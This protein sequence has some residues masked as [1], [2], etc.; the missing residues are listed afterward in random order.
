MQQAGNQTVLVAV[1]SIDG[2]PAG[3]NTLSHCVGAFD[4]VI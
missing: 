3:Q 4:N 1:G 2:A